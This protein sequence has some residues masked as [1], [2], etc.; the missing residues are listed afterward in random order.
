MPSSLESRN[1]LTLQ[2]VDDRILVPERIVDI[3]PGQRR[4]IEGG[5]VHVIH[6]GS[7][8]HEV[9]EV[10]FAAHVAAH[11]EYVGRQPRRV[12]HHEIASAA[13][14]V[15]LLAQDRSCTW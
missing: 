11:H 4:G 14:L 10:M 15:A 6:E 13:P 7:C 5:S 1:D 9:V 12:Q 2:L 8:L 3:E